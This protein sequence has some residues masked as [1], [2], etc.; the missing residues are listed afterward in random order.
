MTSSLLRRLWI[1]IPVVTG[2]G[3][4]GWAQPAPPAAAPVAQAA[5]S[6]VAAPGAPVDASAPIAKKNNPRF[7]QLHEA[8]LR[9]GREAPMGL[10]F[11]GDSITE[12]WFKAPAVWKQYYWKYVPANFGI[13][14]D[15]TQNV[16]WRIENGELDGIEPKV[17]V[18]MLGTNNVASHT[19]AQIAA[20]DRKIV[21][22][23][24]ARIPGVKV[25][26]LAIFP[27]GPRKNT[28]GTMDDGV[29]RM[30]VIHDVNRE[31]SGMDDGRNIRYLDFGAKFLGADGA[32][33]M[34]IMPDQLHP[35]A[36]GYR[37][38]AEAMQPLLD[39]M[40]R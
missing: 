30:Q 35:S 15:T 6:A 10:L 26:L 11:L 33:P 22:M 36:D 18:L 20:A 38:W 14:G 5:P 19:A 4:A 25:L 23:I 32:I 9:R 21:G 3:L 37:I 1:A 13:G 16:V 39:E 8:F 27:R 31:L 2:L 40:M 34:S 24:R 7:Q 17:V 29:K 28:D 12:G